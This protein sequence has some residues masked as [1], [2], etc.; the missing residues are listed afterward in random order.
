M[1]I[2]Y[3]RNVW[4]QIVFSNIL[5]LLGLPQIFPNIHRPRSNKL[6]H[7]TKYG[8]HRDIEVNDIKQCNCYQI[9]LKTQN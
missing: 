4:L 1:L 2:K 7:S 6:L 3:T 8:Y 9:L 5:A